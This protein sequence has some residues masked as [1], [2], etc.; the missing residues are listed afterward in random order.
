[1][2]FPGHA[3]E[4][5]GIAAAKPSPSGIEEQSWS[6]IARPSIAKEGVE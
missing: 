6:L 2:L 5:T 3:G 1:V 4:G